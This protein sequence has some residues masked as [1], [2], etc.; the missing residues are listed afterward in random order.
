MRPWAQEIQPTSSGTRTYLFTDPLADVEQGVLHWTVV[1][2]YS[3]L[4]RLDAYTI[5]C[6]YANVLLF[7]L[8]SRERMAADEVRC[9]T[10][11][12]ELSTM[13][14]SVVSP[15]ATIP[16]SIAGDPKRRA[17]FTDSEEDPVGAH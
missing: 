12:I 16:A 4:F 9:T 7:V 8:N 10:S 15:H 13:Q 6:R 11:D 3:T 17:G 2:G 14:Y 1:S 5:S